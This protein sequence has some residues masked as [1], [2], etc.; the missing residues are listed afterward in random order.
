MRIAST[1]RSPTAQ[2]RGRAWEPPADSFNAVYI[3]YLNNLARVQ[4]FYGGSSSGKSVFLAERAVL[5]VR[6]HRRNYLICR[7][8]GRTL[9]SSVIQEI[10]KVI[11]DWGL[12]NE[13]SIN[14]TDGTVTHHNGY[15]II[16]VGL[17]DVEKL[18]SITPAKGAWT[19]IWIE[20]ATE[21]E[22][23][24]IRQ[25][26]KRQRGG[27]S[28]VPKRL[29]LSFN[30]ILQSHWIYQEYF[31]TIAWADEQT[32]YSGDGLSILKTTYKDNRFLTPDDNR[33]L[34]TETDTYYYNVYTL[35][36]WGVLGNVIFTNWIVADL[37][38]SNDS[39]YLPESQRTNRRDGLDFGFS[40][41]PAAYAATHYDRAHETIYI[42]DEVYERGLTNDVLAERVSPLAGQ[43][44]FVC[45]SAE[46]KSIA[47][48][49]RYNLH[50]LEAKK[51]KDSVIYGIQWLQQQTIV[52]DKRCINAKNEFMAYKWKED[53]NGAA[54]RQPLDKDDHIISAVR[55][56]Y[57]DESLG[58]SYG[59]T[60]Y[61]QPYTIG[62]S[63]Y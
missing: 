37:N 36:N 55:Y 38:D 2:T 42:F 22:R 3:P 35:G 15:Q 21:T 33:D 9:R 39:Y 30:P 41:D 10:R 50:A 18:K 63:E 28:D 34:E 43:V 48:L 44:G 51:G 56:A 32:E 14:K 58:D 54:I 61:A 60:V 20:E 62:S 17:D 6:N 53:K 11:S 12:T 1:P 5:D 29:T 16:F 24:T 25:L 47:E 23:G 59:E 49:R 13:F 40:N 45:D 52:I 46:P 27:D 26:M 57:E 8:V 4:I 19:D 7:Q 31:S